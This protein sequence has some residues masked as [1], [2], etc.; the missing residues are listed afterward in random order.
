RVPPPPRRPPRPGDAAPRVTSAAMDRL[1]QVR[2]VVADD[3]AIWRSGVRA[4]LG[5]NFAV[6]GEAGDADE[7]IEVIQRTS[8]DLVICDL[9]MPNGGG[10]KVARTCGEQTNV[11][12]L[13]VSEAER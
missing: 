2:V 8:P 1:R 13:T 4:D 10:I 3:H 5:E 9:N 7:A 12:M 11:V 6:V